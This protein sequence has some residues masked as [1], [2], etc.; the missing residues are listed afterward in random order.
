MAKT[1]KKPLVSV[2]MP[3]YNVEHYLRQAIDSVLNQ[4]YTNLEL[5][6][7]DDGSRDASGKILDEYKAKD[8]RLVVVHQENQG[9]VAAANYA[10]SIARGE[11]IARQDSDD[12]SFLRRIELQVHAL[13]T[14]P[15]V[16]LVA[17][18]FEGIDEDDEFIYRDILPAEDEDIRRALY[19]RN[20]I[21]H[22]STMFR[23][24]TFLEAGEYGGNGDRRGVAEDYELFVRLAGRGQLLGLEPSLYRWRIN[25]KG[26]TQTQNKLMAEIMQNHIDTRWQSGCPRVIGARELR[27][28]GRDY[29]RTYKKRGIGMKEVVLADNA[30]MAIKMLRYGHP[31]KGLQQL[32]AVALVGRSGIHAVLMRFEFIR[33]GTTAAIRRRMWTH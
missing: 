7:V 17:G 6:A 22:G 28:K 23:R 20:P 16:S 8:N 15:G 3:V 32:I 26:I 25:M 2:I 19:L 12:I 9:V 29:M 24:K 11:Y 1:D 18:C 21:G 5:I 14:H 33:R 4:T 31:L 13:D 30:Q 27:R 10:V